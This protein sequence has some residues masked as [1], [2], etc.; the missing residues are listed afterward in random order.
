MR[1][2]GESKSVRVNNV[3]NCGGGARFCPRDSGDGGAE[4]GCETA[5]EVRYVRRKEK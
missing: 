3:V 1:V 5:S 2:G 4:I